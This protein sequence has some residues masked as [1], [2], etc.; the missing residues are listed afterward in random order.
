[1]D[2]LDKIFAYK[3]LPDPADSILW[4]DELMGNGNGFVSTGPF[5]DWDTNVLMPL[6][7]VPIKRLFRWSKE[8]GELI[9]FGE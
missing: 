3:G 4:A 5:K 7:P 9:I 1:M 8:K 6:S 2:I